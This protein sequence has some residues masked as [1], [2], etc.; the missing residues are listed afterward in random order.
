M[1]NTSSPAGSPPPAII[2]RFAGEWRFLSNFAPCTV[3]LDGEAYPSVEHAFQAAKSDDFRVRQQIRSARTAGHAKRMGRSIRLPAGWG[4]TRVRV[5]R[6]LL[7]QKFSPVAPGTQPDY[8]AGLLRTG[9]AELIEGNDWGDKFWGKVNGEGANV[10][11]QLLMELRT[12]RRAG[13]A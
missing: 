2:D 6:G 5:M 10:L 13:L 4:E 3:M 7:W 1:G 8:L 11:G 9:D 12:V